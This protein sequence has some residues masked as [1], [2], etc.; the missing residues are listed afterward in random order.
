MINQGKSGR[1]IS[2]QYPPPPLPRIN[3]IL[4]TRLNKVFDDHKK[5]N[6]FPSFSKILATRL[7]RVLMFVPFYSHITRDLMD[8]FICVN[9]G[10][11]QNL[12]FF[13][14]KGNFLGEIYRSSFIQQDFYI[15]QEKRNNITS[16]IFSGKLHSKRIF[17]CNMLQMPQ[18]YTTTFYVKS[19]KKI[20]KKVISDH[21]HSIKLR[22]LSTPDRTLALYII[23]TIYYPIYLRK[24]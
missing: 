18:F 2:P 7:R 8:S 16:L 12:L 24:N 22:L 15:R 3:K 21:V 13:S 23:E 6:L 1:V 5:Q 11:T 14:Y 9:F 20:S 17:S 4:T 19:D 10:S